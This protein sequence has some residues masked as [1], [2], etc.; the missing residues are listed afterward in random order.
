MNDYKS[1]H[2][3]IIMCATLIRSHPQTHKLFT[4][5][6]LLAQPDGPKNYGIEYNTM[7]YFQRSVVRT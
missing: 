6:I 2:V 5:A 4:A 7:S 3:A 1:L